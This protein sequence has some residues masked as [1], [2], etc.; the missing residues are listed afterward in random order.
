MSG[1]L[2]EHQ[3]KQVGHHNPTHVAA[4]LTVGELDFLGYF[5]DAV[6]PIAAHF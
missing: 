4:L 1:K 5:H 6:G 2:G 3:G